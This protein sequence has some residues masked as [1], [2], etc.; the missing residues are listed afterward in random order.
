MPVPSRSLRFGTLEA[1]LLAAA[2][3]G[4]AI[5][6]TSRDD[7]H[8]VVARERVALDEV[9]AIERAE[10]TFRASNRRDDD[11][12][13]RPEYGSLEDLVGAGLLAGP[14]QRDA[15]GP[16]LRR[17]SYRIEVLL[18]TATLPSGQREFGRG[19]AAIDPKLTAATFAVVALPV[20]GE[21]R[22][23]RSFYADGAGYAFTSEGVNEADRDPTAPPPLRELRGDDERGGHEDGP[24]WRPTRKPPDATAPPPK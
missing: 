11:A 5:V 9:A 22:V 10:A 2:L 13:G 1:V 15:D 8:T 20:R 12:D 23:L 18:P 4:A 6:G 19:G 7:G 16:H 14:V 24:I 17:G 3:A 21:P